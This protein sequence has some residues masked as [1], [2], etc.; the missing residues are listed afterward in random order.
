[1][2]KRILTYNGSIVEEFYDEIIEGTCSCGQP[3]HKVV[4][5]SIK[6]FKTGER[7]HYPENNTGWGIVNC[8]NCSG[9]I[10]NTFKAVIINKSIIDI[11]VKG[12]FLFELK[13]KSDWV[14]K[15]PR[16]LPNKIRAGESW[17]WVDKNGNVFERGADFSS[18]EELQT[19]PCKVYRLQSISSIN[20]IKN[21]E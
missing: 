16:I 19:Y 20:K 9:L 2:N 6:T 18:A 21:H 12:E 7:F 13:S 5:S 15:V 11:T 17:I 10:I 3:V 1:M 4:D 8:K 14:N